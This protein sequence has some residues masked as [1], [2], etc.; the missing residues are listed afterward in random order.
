MSKKYDFFYLPI[1]FK[2]NWNVGYAFINL[3]DP[4]LVVPF[5]F[6]FAKKKW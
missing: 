6:Q 5:Y 3:I 1:D 2:N 4:I